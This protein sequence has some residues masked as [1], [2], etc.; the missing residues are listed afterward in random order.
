MTFFWPTVC[1]F[2][3][4]KIVS[5]F[6][7]PSTAPEAS[8]PSIEVGAYYVE[9]RAIP[10]TNVV[11]IKTATTETVQRPEY[12]RTIEAPIAAWLYKH[13]LQDKILY[14]VLTKGVP[15]RVAGTG[16]REAT[17]ASVD[18]ELTLLYRKMTGAAIPAVGRIA[19]PYYLAD[20]PVNMAKRFTRLVSQNP[21]FALELMR[22]LT[23]RVRQNLTS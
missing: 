15:I 3:A 14:I 11:R 13:S 4:V 20:Q 17:T 22:L 23:Q 1:S 19:N 6:S 9:K 2:A 8:A 12:E 10:A 18:S 7:C 21:H 16:G 5:G